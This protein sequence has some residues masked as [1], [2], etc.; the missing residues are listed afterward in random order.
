MLCV[1]ER[2]RQTETE[3]DRDREISG[4]SPGGFYSPSQGTEKVKQ[5]YGEELGSDVQ[6]KVSWYDGTQMLSRLWA[7]WVWRQEDSQSQRCGFWSHQHVSGE[8]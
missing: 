4:F 7:M 8:W 3:K 5:G 6:F 2:D 1:G